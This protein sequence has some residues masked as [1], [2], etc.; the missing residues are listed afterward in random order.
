MDKHINKKRVLILVA[1]MLLSIPNMPI[2]SAVGSYS[3]NSPNL[4]GNSNEKFTGV[5]KK[6]AAW[7]QAI[8]T[9]YIAGRAIGTIA[10]HVYHLLD[11][12]PKE[13]AIVSVDYSPSDFSKFDN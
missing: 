11:G 5:D 12:H 3:T 6:K 1:V 2:Y 7:W 13:L 10:H 4:V 8:A 9:S